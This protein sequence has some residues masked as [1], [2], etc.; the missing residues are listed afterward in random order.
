MEKAAEN[1]NDYIECHVFSR[2]D[3]VAYLRTSNTSGIL[4]NQK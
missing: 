2:E 3:A 1:S 4:T